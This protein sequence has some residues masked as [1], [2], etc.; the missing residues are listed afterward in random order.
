MRHGLI[1]PI[2]AGG[3]DE[4]GAEDHHELCEGV[5]EGFRRVVGRGGHENGWP[6]GSTETATAATSDFLDLSLPGSV[7]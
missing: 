3:D 2:G 1:A 4:L 7:G 6:P 5:T